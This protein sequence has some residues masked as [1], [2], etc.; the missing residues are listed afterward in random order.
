MEEAS[1]KEL[2]TSSTRE[3]EHELENRAA[4]SFLFRPNPHV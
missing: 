4:F 2:P 3:D 1:T